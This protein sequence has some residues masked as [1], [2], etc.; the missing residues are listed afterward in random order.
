YTW[1]KWQWDTLFEGLLH[2]DPSY[3]LGSIICINQSM[4]TLAIQS[5]ELVDGQQRL[6]T[7]SLLMTAIH[8]SYSNLDVELD[9]EDIVERLNL[10]HKLALKGKVE[11]SRL[12]PQVQNNNQQDYYWTLKEAK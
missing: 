12:V 11:Q 7:L 9:E 4:D 6:T 3:F 8:H 1:G 2:N 10:K 5:L